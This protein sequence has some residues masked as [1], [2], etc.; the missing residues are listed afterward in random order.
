MKGFGG[1]NDLAFLYEHRIKSADQL[2]NDGVVAL[3]TAIFCSDSLP[4]G[5]Y[6][7]GS[8]YDPYSKLFGG[9]LQIGNSHNGVYQCALNMSSIALHKY[10]RGLIR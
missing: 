7:T 6:G 4:G 1:Y 2:N 10:A 9:C 3:V 5:D 8:E